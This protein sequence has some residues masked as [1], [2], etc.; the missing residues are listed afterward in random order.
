MNTRTV[1]NDHTG[2][3]G[4]GAGPLVDPVDGGGEPFAGAQQVVEVRYT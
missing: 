3:P 2:A 4:R 1:T